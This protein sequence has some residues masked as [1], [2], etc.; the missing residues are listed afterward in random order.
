MKKHKKR[1]P[2]YIKVV[3]GREIVDL[4]KFLGPIDFSYLFHEANK[5]VF[6]NDGS[7]NGWYFSAAGWSYVYFR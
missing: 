2:N 4:D 7:G 1:K 5:P 3:D 6:I